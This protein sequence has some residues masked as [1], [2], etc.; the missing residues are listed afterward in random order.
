MTKAPSLL[1][2]P[3]DLESSI[4]VHADSVLDHDNAK[5]QVVVEVSPVYLVISD[6]RLSCLAACFEATRF[7][8]N[9][10]S[11]R[12]ETQSLL[13]RPPRLEVLSRLFRLSIDLKVGRLRLSLTRD[14]GFS[15]S[16][17]LS[18]ES[19]M[20]EYLVDFLTIASSFDLSFPHEEALS[21]AM[22][23][24][25]DRLNGIGLQ[26]DEAWE[27]TNMALLRLLEVLSEDG[28]SMASTLPSGVSP[29]FG[30]EADDRN[31]SSIRETASRVVSAFEHCFGLSRQAGDSE[32]ALNHLVL[33]MPDGVE[34][35]LARLFYDTFCSICVSSIFVTNS[36]GIHLLRITSPS[37]SHLE[38]DDE[39]DDLQS[40]AS[41]DLLLQNDMLG[42]EGVAAGV[43]LRFFA[44]DQSLR[45]GRGGMPL[46][47]LGVDVAQEVEDVKSELLSD[48][49]VGD[50][51]FL[52]SSEVFE[53]I[54]TSCANAFSACISIKSSSSN[55]HEQASGQRI[56]RSALLSCSCFSTLFLADDMVP[57]CR[58]SAS[59]VLSKGVTDSETGMTQTIG[60]NALSVMNLTKEGEMYP[61]VAAA[62]PSLSSTPFFVSVTS[63]GDHG[64]ANAVVIFDGF[65]VVFLRQFTHE[66]VQFISSSE[67][68]LGLLRRRLSE[69]GAPRNPP[70][71]RPTHLEIVFRD[72][73]LIVPESCTSSNILCVE[74]GSLRVSSSRVSDSIRLPSEGSPLFVPGVGPAGEFL[75][76][77]DCLDDQS[78]LSQGHNDDA[79][80]RTHVLLRGVRFYTSISLQKSL[81]PEFDS[82][83]FRYFYHI[84]GRAEAG[85]PVYARY[86]FTESEPLPAGGVP[87]CEQIRDRRW[88]ELTAEE[89]SFDV[90]VEHAAVF[91]LLVCDPLIQS[92][93]PSPICLSATT[94][95]F[96]LL[97]SVWYINM[98]EMPVT[99]PF[100][101]ERVA[102]Q[103]RPFV[104]DLGPEPSSEE[105]ERFMQ[106]SY[107]LV[108]ES[109]FSFESLTVRFV[110]SP[111][112]EAI[113]LTLLDAFVYIPSEITLFTKVSL[114]ARRA[115]LCDESRDQP[116]VLDTGEALQSRRSWPDFDF[117]LKRSFSDI[118]T[119]L[120]QQF[121]LS[122]FLAPK[123]SF[124]VLG[125]NE[126]TIELN[127]FSVVSRF[128]EFVTEYFTDADLGHPGIEATERTER[129]KES[130]RNRERGSSHE[131]AT[132]ASSDFRLWM[133]KPVLSVPCDPSS[134]SS[135]GLRI[136]S[137]GGLWYRIASFADTSLQEVASDNLS[138]FFDDRFQRGCQKRPHVGDTMRPLVSDLSLGVRVEH[139]YGLSHSDYAIRI[140]FVD[141]S[142]CGIRS[143]PLSVPPSV[144]DFPTICSPFQ[145]PRECMGQFVCEVTVHIDALPVA[146][147]ALYTLFSTTSSEGE[148]GMDPV[149]GNEESERSTSCLVGSFSDIRVF[150]LDPVLGP[151]LPVAVASVKDVDITMS[152]FDSQEDGN[153]VEGPAPA[154][155][156]FVCDAVLWAQYFKLGL[157]RSWEP[158][159]EPYAARLLY[160]RSATRGNGICLSSDCPLHINVTSALL[161]IIDEVLN[162]FLVLVRS[163]FGGDE[164]ATKVATTTKTSNPNT[165]SLSFIS[166]P[167][168]LESQ[169]VQQV[170]RPLDDDSRVA[171][172]L[173]NLTGQRI[174]MHRPRTG[175]KG[176]TSEH[177][178]VS[179]VDH[180][181][182]T[183][184]VFWPTISVVRN[185]SI[186]EVDYPGLPNSRTGNQVDHRIDAHALSVQLPGFRWFDDL[187]VETFGR[188][189]EAV[190]PRSELVLRKAS[191]W[192]VD[193]VLKL[194]V[195]VG[196]EKGGRQVTLRSLFSVSNKTGHRLQISVN[197]DANYSPFCGS[198]NDDDGS[199]E[200][201]DVYHVPFL[202]IEN[203]LRKEGSHMGSVWVRPSF[204]DPHDLQ[205]KPFLAETKDRTV[206]VHYSSRPLELS[207][208]VSETAIL[209]EQTSGQEITPEEGRTAFQVSCPVVVG[210][211]GDR[212][213]PFCYAVEVCRSPVVKARERDEASESKRKVSAGYRSV[214]GP[215]AYSLA[216]HPPLVLV[217]LLPEKGRFELMHAVRNT[218]VWFGDL[219]PGQQVAVHSVGLDAP[220]LLLVNL[221]FCRTPVGEGA[222]IHHG[223]DPPSG[224]RGT[225]HVG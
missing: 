13:A 118:A 47:M 189:F 162:S 119:R 92:S 107:P 129:I 196:L 2:S 221:G 28:M 88:Q 181:E 125:I 141:S 203:A 151:H 43:V 123:W 57:F 86:A 36:E 166:S 147:S 25:I 72:S 84:D 206:D 59:E 42:P 173:R 69:L 60:A 68:G 127:D 33:D 85:K 137:D 1:E 180:M 106:R 135:S 15:P 30:E 192:R 96:C 90:V 157:T 179:Y 27:A 191:D 82:A 54:I 102:S 223:S 35:S 45:F 214:H 94:E 174:R 209:F 8:A 176:S 87:T 122:A 29:S 24:C 81:R 80:S 3:I 224:S 53:E 220:L 89:V 4:V 117:G 155:F 128:L 46:S 115:S 188:T 5:H 23:I 64:E 71:G 78:T 58:L 20:A 14:S 22:Q 17:F 7:A 75:D 120:P 121:M 95:Q 143:P 130:L 169:V 183:E 26:V 113:R 142:A 97:L 67:Y 16:S 104:S 170:A 126:P 55:E 212:L 101:A 61:V 38:A 202:L 225:Y 74:V 56:R 79:F 150:A 182:A 133:Y 186:I 139:D 108:A 134:D 148:D 197:P 171:F 184:V 163:S 154:N 52:F 76:C 100:D 193:N 185:L 222:L 110:T 44:V 73:S 146:L 167:L 152:Q 158:L 62:I 51:E 168:V 40:G 48:V 145:E 39:A 18:K 12:Q 204:N 195:E 187:K 41:S 144:V 215:V 50:V 9:D 99:F 21:S 199:I 19:E 216:I 208:V 131:A 31:A 200:P 49:E 164:T 165:P 91:R 136:T 77:M 63:S 93:P 156:Q 213:T 201:G 114:S 175:P 161:S 66:C 194:L 217:N 83:A 32:S 160:E 172:S 124:Y 10:N 132:R 103:A 111:G 105:W 198:S 6:K 190:V 116:C 218:V 11:S 98:K 159:V 219:D 178:V 34:V 112:I 207:K 37:M 211:S 65:R 149:A 153:V 210:S 138:L 205:L 177:H 70:S 109:M 140:P